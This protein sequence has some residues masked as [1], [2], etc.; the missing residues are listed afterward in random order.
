VV[1]GFGVGRQ[2][3]IDITTAEFVELFDELPLWSAPFA[4]PLLERVPLRAGLTFLDVGAGTGFLTIE[5]AER[6]GSS[7]TVIAVDPWEAALARLERKAAQRGLA[8]VT[9][10]A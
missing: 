9:V 3:G 7:A 10:R 8:N 5:L 2:D 4:L 6:C 1:V